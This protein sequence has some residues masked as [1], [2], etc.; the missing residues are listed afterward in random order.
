MRTYFY[1]L[2][3]V[4]SAFLTILVIFHFGDL[5][6][7]R[8][9]GFKRSYFP[10]PFSEIQIDFPDTL[11]EI[12]GSTPWNIYVSLAREGEVLEI[13]KRPGSAIKRIK[14]PF[15]ARYY[16]SLQFY[17]LSI[18]I[19]SPHIYLFSENKPAIV[20][21]NFD[22]TQFEIKIL[23]PGPFTRE[24][25]AG[26][27]C[28][29]LRK[30]ESR[31][32]DQLFVRYN[33]STGAIKKEDTISPIY[34]D[35]GIVSD[36]QLH[37]DSGAKKLYYI[38]YYKNLLL[39][40]DTM[41]GAVNRYHSI[42]TTRSF[43]M[44]T[45]L[46]ENSGTRAYT[47][48]SPANIINKVSYAQNGLLFNM[49]GLRADNESDEFFSANSILDVIDMNSGGYLGSLILPALKGD[50]LS[51]FILSDDKL[52]GLYTNSMIVYDMNGVIR[53]DQ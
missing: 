6:N 2:L 23:P 38:Y 16:D 46:V 29:I 21:T 37:F 11:H 13:G 40:F 24:V 27:D 33:F 8:N 9:N 49:S 1:L 7:K 19:D 51:Q 48:I 5:P 45:G 22:S 47:N 34:G 28:F 3:I 26:T 50:K 39:E 25:M 12:I 18:K 36:G 35:G 44:R 4:I 20:K 31:R 42:D 41:L 30:F 14:I 32:M 10:K 15:F 53:R 43:K 17:S 52:I